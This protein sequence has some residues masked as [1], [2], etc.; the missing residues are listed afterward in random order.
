MGDPQVTIAA[1]AFSAKMV[2]HDYWICPKLALTFQCE[3]IYDEEL[4]GGFKHFL[5]SI[6]YGIILPID[7]HYSEG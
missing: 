4:V 2:I 7:F 3:A 6:I 1:I 5:F